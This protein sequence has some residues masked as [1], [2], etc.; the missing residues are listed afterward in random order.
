MIA[1]YD[2]APFYWLIAALSGLPAA[3]WMYLGV[4]LPWALAIAPRRDWR[5]RPF[6]CA[7]ALALGPAWTTA[8]MLL[9]GSIGAAQ[10]IPTLRWD[11]VLM[12]T[13]A[14]S[15]VGLGIAMRKRRHRASPPSQLPKPWRQDEKLLVALIIIA[16]ALRWLTTAYWPFTAYDELWVYGYEGRLY[17]LKGFI[18]QSIGYYPQFLPLQ[19]TYMQLA[20]GGINDH[21][22]RTVLPFLHV[23]SI[24][25]AYVLGARLINRRTGVILA[26]LWALYPHLSDWAHVGDLEVPLTFLF[27]LASTLFLMAWLATE[28]PE[29][30]HYALMSG[31]IL[32]IAM[33]TKPT[34][35]AFVWGVMLVVSISAILHRLH[36]RLWWPQFEVAFLVGIACLP[37]GA[38]WYLR[39]IALG[40]A[41]IDLPHESWLLLA[42]RSGDLWSWTALA[43]TLWALTTT[44]KGRWI[45]IAGVALILAGLLPSTPLLFPHRSNPPASY[46]SPLEALSVISGA[47]V[48]LWSARRA[49]WAQQETFQVIFWGSLL[50]LPYFITYFFSYSYHYRL[51]FA[52]VPLMALPSAAIL[53]K[54]NLFKRW[55]SAHTWIRAGYL[56]LIVSLAIPGILDTAQDING[57]SGWLFGGDYPHDVARYTTQNPEVVITAQA[58]DNYIAKTGEQPIVIAPG[59]QRLRFFFPLATI[60]E[61]TQPTKLTDL[62]GAS[63]F[64]YGALARWRYED[65]DLPLADNQIVNALARQDIMTRVA[66]HADGVFRYE[67]Y[68]LHLD[69]RFVAPQDSHVLHLIEDEVCWAGAICYLGD[70]VS[71]LNFIAQEPVDV[72]F[73]W[74]A[75]K[76]V[77]TDAQIRVQLFNQEDDQIYATW[78]FYPA[79]GPHGYYSTRFW[80]VGELVS[81][82]L[83]LQLPH[84]TR[85]PNGRQYKLLVQLISSENGAVWPLYINGQPADAMPL[86]ATFK[87]ITE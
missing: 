55:E 12:G 33:W 35:G 69:K 36:W 44:G 11:W 19:Y 64:L 26:A 62:N 1:S 16:L 18:P 17:F 43:L 31:L 85:L 23:G 29:K 68:E 8:W 7:I 83:R 48:L 72:D 63:H 45:Q 27:T 65:F 70:N 73:L 84:N 86:V 57:Y 6:I 2:S 24:L 42:R 87:V 61:K 80:D 41:A 38:I 54:W 67:L 20:I 28:K 53:G 9:L 78:D 32:G 56:S 60:V 77:L 59:E 46:I 21:V 82:P 50:A 14:I 52:I 58:L 75:Q 3:L 22:A 39:N 49:A 34:A 79:Q 47:L 40:H 10:N 81:T 76:P 4:G 71:T 13:V 25:S 30:R 51:S 37:L 66:Q 15:A 5:D 74:R